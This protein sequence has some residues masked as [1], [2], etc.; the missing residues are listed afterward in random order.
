MR[1]RTLLLV[2]AH[3]RLGSERVPAAGG[4]MLEVGRQADAEGRQT[5]AERLAL[6]I[7]PCCLLNRFARRA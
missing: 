6:V 2:V 5:R 1:T 3:G 7:A 4:R